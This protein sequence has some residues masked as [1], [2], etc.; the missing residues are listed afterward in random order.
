M[1]ASIIIPV[2]NG[3]EYL[4]RCF[5]ALRLQS[6]SDF[7]IIAVDNNST[8][9]SVNFIANHYPQVSLIRNPC[10]LGFAGGCNVGLRAAKGDILVLLNQDTRVS[11]DWLS[12]LAGRLQNPEV[13]VVGCKALYPD[14]QT[15]QH[16]GGWIEWPLGLAHHYGQGESDSGQWDEPRSLDYVTGAAMAF[17]REILE[18]VGFLDEGFWPGYFEDADFCF[19][20]RE[21]GF[22]VK[23]DP[24]AVV[25]HEETTSIDAAMVSRAYQRGRLRFLLKHMSPLRFLEEFV[26][27]EEDYQPPAIR[28]WESS[29]LPLAYLASIPPAVRILHR[30]GGVSTDVAYQV[31]AALKQ[32]YQRA[33]K[34]NSIH[35]E[36]LANAISQ[37]ETLED[38]ASSLSHLKEFEFH[39]SLPVIGPLIVQLRSVWYSIAAQW[40]VR[41]LV[42][43]QDEINRQQDAVNRRQATLIQ[44]QDTYIRS[45]EKR[46]ETLAAENALLAE[47][48]ARIGLQIDIDEE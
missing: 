28:G 37:S 14:G 36:E 26:P 6:Y 2:W 3:K 24:K 1:K 34:E 9:G 5:D 18:R 43:Q 22:E 19:L 35:T 16:A 25:I 29:A 32:L 8:D 31:V 44:Q 46:V 4:S 10:N 48:I 39:S 17:R 12:V 33:W 40:P 20:V 27:A 13:G 23:Y 21:A 11:P 15:I 7:E 38:F 30:R 45:L 47:E 42:Q 41:H